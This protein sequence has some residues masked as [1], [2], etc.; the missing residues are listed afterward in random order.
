M[1]NKLIDIL[2]FFFYLIT[3]CLVIGIIKSFYYI[4]SRF[5]IFKILVLG[6][7]NYN[8]NIIIF[9]VFVLIFE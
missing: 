9:K 2:F 4:K 6:K 5:E 1:I 7:S 8:Y 3:I